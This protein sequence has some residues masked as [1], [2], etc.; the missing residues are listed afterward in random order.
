MKEQ[1]NEHK[2]SN[3]LNPETTSPLFKEYHLIF[4]PVLT[5][6]NILPFP[7]EVLISESSHLHNGDIMSCHVASGKDYKFYNF[8]LSK[9]I[10]LNFKIQDFKTTQST[11][12][13]S[14]NKPDLLKK[15]LI[16]NFNFP[17]FL[18]KANICK[19]VVIT[20]RI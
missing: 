2:L 15:Y 3:S 13:H 18:I 11:E 7:L 10:K 1:E 4:K 16:L 20:L 17:H 8:D 6:K 14:L 12:L 9:S 5:V 19:R